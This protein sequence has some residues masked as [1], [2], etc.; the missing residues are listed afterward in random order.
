MITS[1][2]AT[3]VV[4][5]DVEGLAKFYRDVLGLPLERE[6]HGGGGEALHFGC[7]LGAVHFAVHP[8]DNWPG[9][10]ETGPGGVR[11]AFDVDDAGAEAERLRGAGVNAVGPLEMGWAKLVLLRDPDGNLVELVQMRRRASG[12]P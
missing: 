7:A 3:I 5:R 10:E 9:A 11:L 1:L 4:T 12:D 8:V 6:Q 2:S